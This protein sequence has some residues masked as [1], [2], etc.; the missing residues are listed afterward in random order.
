MT[1]E[2]LLVREIADGID[3]AA[4]QAKTEADLRAAPDLRPL[5]TPAV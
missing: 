2:G 3:F 4:L 5:K 1:P